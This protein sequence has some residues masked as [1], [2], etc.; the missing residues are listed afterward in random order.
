M[1]YMYIFYIIVLRTNLK[2]S[3]LNLYPNI[4]LI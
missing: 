3:V 1:L 2:D 4:N